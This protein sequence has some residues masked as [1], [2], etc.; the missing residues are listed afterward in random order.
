[1]NPES[2]RG[3][4]KLALP[5]L[6]RILPVRIKSV[7]PLSAHRSQ[8]GKAGLER[9]HQRVDLRFVHR[10]GER[11]RTSADDAATFAVKMIEQ[12]LESALA[13]APR[14]ASRRSASG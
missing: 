8:L 12:R 13:P 14:A 1:M 9:P 7:P 11:A 6:Q 5:P 2:F 3:Q 10:R 4:A